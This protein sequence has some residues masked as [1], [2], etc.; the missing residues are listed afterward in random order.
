MEYRETGP[1]MIGIELGGWAGGMMRITTAGGELHMQSGVESLGSTWKPGW[2]QDTLTPSWLPP[3]LSPVPCQSFGQNFA[4]SPP[5]LGLVLGLYLPPPTN[6]FFSHFRLL[7]V[8]LAVPKSGQ[9][10]LV[11]REFPATPSYTVQPG[12]GDRTSVD[13]YYFYYNYKLLLILQNNT[14]GGSWRRGP[15]QCRA[16]AGNTGPDQYWQVNIG[17]SPCKAPGKPLPAIPPP[18]QAPC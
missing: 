15:Q 10:S 9:I 1:D 5:P 17:R 18:H 6:H 13:D 4:A 16:T 12:A 14:E 11:S 7:S 3:P 2:S 8:F